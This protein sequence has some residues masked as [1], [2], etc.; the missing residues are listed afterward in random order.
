MK[1]MTADGLQGEGDFVTVER[2]ARAWKNRT[3]M[4]F[5]F[6]REQCAEKI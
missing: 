2:E 5:G 3:T 4:V 6:R 1:S